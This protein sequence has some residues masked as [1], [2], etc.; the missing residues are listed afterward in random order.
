MMGSALTFPLADR[1]HTVR[2]VGTHLD[3]AIIDQVRDNR[4]HPKL[5]LALPEQVIPYS[6]SELESAATGVDAIALGVS[7]A[8]IDW[9]CRAI[10]PFVEPGC[11]L[12]M[13]TKGLVLEDGELRTLPDVVKARLPDAVRASVSPS[14]IAGPCIAGELARRVPTCVVLAGHQADALTAVTALLEGPY[15]RVFPTTDVVGAEVSAALKNAY[16][17]GIAFAVGKNERAGGSGGSIAMH[18]LESAIM[19]QSV[20][21]MAR[22]A[23][24]LGGARNTVASL[25]GVGDLDVTTNGGRTGRFGRLLGLGLPLAEAIERMEGATLE[26]L[27]ILAVMKSAITAGII[28]D[29]TYAEL[30]L[31]A[32]LIAVALE[33]AKADPPIDK[34][35][36]RGLS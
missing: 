3:Q 4:V 35:F 6:H 29:T 32:H 27:E 17:M 11:L 31:L 21:E 7:S 1:G 30:P 5:G 9:A 10:A 8:G 2:L 24:K 22:I 23:S 33:G 34:F 15:Y 26:C 19:A 36:G 13:I 16:A 28:P 12:F 14:A 20:V 18:N 25:A